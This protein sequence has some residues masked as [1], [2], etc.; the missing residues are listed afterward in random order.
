MAYR[1]DVEAMEARLADLEHQV[2]D[3]TR[4]RDELARMIADA[5]SR[6]RRQAIFDDLKAGGPTRRLY[7][8]AAITVGAI[9]IASLGVVA[10]RATTRDKGDRFVKKFEQFTDQICRCTDKACADKITDEITRWS[11]E[12]A[13]ID[14]DRHDAPDEA[15]MKRMS[16]VAEKYTA[17]LTKLLSN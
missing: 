4:E 16:T 2:G 15:T 10:Y 17:C 6:A 12:E 8:N 3:V 1:S 5:R 11:T 13:A 14:A 7:R 9:A